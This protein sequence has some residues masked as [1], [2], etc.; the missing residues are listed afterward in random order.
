MKLAPKILAAFILGASPSCLIAP[1]SALPIGTGP[2][3]KDASSDVETVRVASR[4]GGIGVAG[5]RYV[6]AGRYAGARPWVGGPGWRPGYGLAAGA[7]IGGAIA[8]S[9]PSYGDAGYGYGAYYG[10]DPSYPTSYDTG[11]GYP[12]G[13]YGYGLDPGE[14]Y[15]RS[16]TYVG[17]PKTESWMCR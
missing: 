3:L 13:A 11:P 12:Y 1:V 7:V 2:G 5:G 9:Q 16:C 6:G 17:G 15:V 10:S 8:A 14:P 4:V